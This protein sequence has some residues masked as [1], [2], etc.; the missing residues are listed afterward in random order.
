VT[1]NLVGADGTAFGAQWTLFRQALAPG[2]RQEG[3]ANQQLWMGHA[4]VTRA[5]SHRFAET[6]ARGGVG[7]AG[8]DAQPFR[9]WIDARQMRGP[10]GMNATT[11]SP[12]E[13][14]ASG[15]DFDYTL[16]LEAD[17][18]LVLQGE[19]GYSRKTAREQASYYYSQ[20]F[21]TATGRLSIDGLAFDVTG[22][23]WM[24]REWSSQPL[25]SDQT[26]WDWLALHLNSGDRRP[27]ASGAVGGRDPLAFACDRM[28]TAQPES[29]D[30]NEFLLLGGTDPFSWQP[31]GRGISRNDRLLARDWIQ[32]QSPASLRGGVADE[33]IQFCAFVFWIASLRAQ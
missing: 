20:P 1:A 3:W 13:V 23:A 26:G 16:R 12:L 18:G 11:I 2:A 25:A 9:A 19:R 10:D 32:V 22:L 8:V 21:F 5:D 31:H 7:Q 30:G 27:Q 29:L 6:F 17:R 4:A 33:A 24:D 28:H 14:S 15:N